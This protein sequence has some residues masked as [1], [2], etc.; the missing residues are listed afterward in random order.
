V[1]SRQQLMWLLRSYLIGCCVSIALLFVSYVMGLTISNSGRYT[2]GGMNAN[3]LALLLDIGII[4]AA[5][6]ATSH[7]SQLKITYYLFILPAALGILLTG[8]R[9]GTIGLVA[10]L[11]IAFIISWSVSWKSV[12]L[13]VLTVGFA[14]W[15]IPSIVPS[16]L[17]ERVT[18][19]TTAHTFVER[20]V[21][22]NAGLQSWREVPITGVG[23]GA[24]IAAVTAKGY[25]ALVAHNTFVQILVDNG[26]VG[27][28]LMVVIWGLLAR[29]AWCLPPRERFLWL[30]VGG[31]WIV[32]AMSTSLEYFKITWFLY[33]WIML[34]PSIS[35]R[36]AHTGTGHSDPFHK[37]SSW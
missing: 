15:L 2:G 16:T 19:G 18:E 29:L 7:T 25:P 11:T 37:Q 6:L 35:S 13:V 33:A 12:L 17:L 34:Q 22:W 31:V 26:I 28:T 20:Q 30:G 36:I 14:A 23:A 21:Q 8:S 3:N 5:Y 1:D 24:F 4:I 32:V 27:M 10:S 9:A